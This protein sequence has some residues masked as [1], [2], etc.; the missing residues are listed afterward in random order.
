MKTKSLHINTQ[1]THYFNIMDLLLTVI[2]KQRFVEIINK[3]TDLMFFKGLYED[4][5]KDVYNWTTLTIV[6]VECS[7]SKHSLIYSTLKKSL[8]PKTIF[9]IFLVLNSLEK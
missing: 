6:D 9:C 2:Y 4:R 3:N 8:S 5:E 7:F 1:F